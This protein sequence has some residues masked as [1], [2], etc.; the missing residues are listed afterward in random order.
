M[1]N[2]KVRNVNEA[3]PIAIKHLLKDGVEISSRG[4]NTIE[5]PE[6]VC[7]TYL[8]PR[9][10]VL[11]S[12]ERD[13]NPFFHFM[14]ALWIIAGRR[15]V[16]WLS[17]FNSRIH[18]YSDDG[19]VFHAPYGYRMCST[20]GGIDQIKKIIDRFKTEPDTRQAVISIW[21]PNLDLG[22]EG[23]DCP[24]NNII[25]FKIRN[26]KLN[27][28]VCCR[29]N[30]MLWG[31]YGANVVQFSTLQEYIAI[32]IGIEV[33]VYN[34][35]SDSF[36]VYLDGPGNKCWKRVVERTTNSDF[37]SLW[38]SPFV[39]MNNYAEWN[40]DLS[41]FF[42]DPLHE[43]FKEPYFYEVAKPMFAVWEKYKSGHVHTAIGLSRNI[44]AEDWNRACL[45]W[46]RRRIK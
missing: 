36:H 3:L 14:E 1:L 24:C 17:K 43:G 31:A 38:G 7:T 11:F 25:F 26:G 44:K 20:F 22:Y 10:R 41:M 39:L 37:Y 33:G 30:D 5:Y 6:P 32:S 16:E 19:K 9:E 2:I 45:E 34:Q 46:L 4:M 18:E 23:K 40:K 12:P 15:D 21:S 28:S 13:A 29:S 8:N 27:M 35:I 42:T